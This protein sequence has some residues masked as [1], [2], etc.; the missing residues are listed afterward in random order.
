MAL[1]YD[2]KWFKNVWST[3]SKINGHLQS[4]SVVYYWEAIFDKLVINY[5]SKKRRRFCPELKAE[6]SLDE[7]R[8]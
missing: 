4:M 8:G 5:Q 3:D 7:I 6:I 2:H 1:F